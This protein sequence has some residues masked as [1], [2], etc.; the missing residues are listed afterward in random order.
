MEWLFLC[1]S[2]VSVSF[3]GDKYQLTTDDAINACKNSHLVMKHSSDYDIDPFIISSIIWHE[4]RWN[5]EVV[6]SAGACGLTQVMPGFEKVKCKELFDP[7]T[8]IMFSAKILR[9]YKNMHAEKKITEV[10]DD[11]FALSCY[12]VGPKC[13]KSTY[14]KRHTRGVLKLAEKYKQVYNL[15]SLD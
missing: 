6:S 5:N 3:S 15:F 12:A 14:A 10:S 4:S 13:L 2:I 11:F 8:A 9:I 1:F 7:D